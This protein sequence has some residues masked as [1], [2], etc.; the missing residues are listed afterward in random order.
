MKQLIV[1]CVL[2]FPR[3]LWSQYAATLEAEIALDR[4][5]NGQKFEVLFEP[6]WRT[7]LTDK[8]E[9]TFLGQIRLD[10][11]GDLGPNASKPANYDG[12]NGPIV[13]SNHAAM[14]IREWYIDTQVADSFWRV[15]K[16]QVVWGQAD[17]VRVLDVINPQSYR[18]AFLDDFEDARIPLWMINMEIAVGENGNLQVIWIPD[19]SYNEQAVRSSPF[20]IT[21]PSLVRSSSFGN[22]VYT[23][24]RNNIQDSDYGI[25]YST[26]IDGW[27]L[28]ANYF[29]HYHD[30]PTPYRQFENEKLTFSNR[31]NRNHLVGGTA[32]KAFG[33]FT[34][35]TEVGLNSD[36]FHLKRLDESDR[37]DSSGVH[38]SSEIAALVGIDWQGFENTMVSMQWY[39]STILDDDPQ[40]YRPK[41]NTL[42]SLLYRR[43]LQNEVWELEALGLHSKSTN[44][45]S[46]QLKVS[47][48]LNSNLNVWLGADLFYGQRVGLFGQFREANRVTVGFKWGI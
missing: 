22:Q 38:R 31:H 25:R 19:L 43:S 5:Q 28:T 40:L 8:T 23:K 15:G 27:D 32:S 30:N 42:L 48:V 20:A 33:S 46:V 26:F 9:M 34:L 35:R 41:T 36:T 29:Y 3:V 11:I 37:G 24:P 14:T 21:S 6:E 7:S 17:G 13:H 2:F 47:Y 18:E 10:A 39:R 4:N 12:V 1:M 45:G 16:Q 44:D